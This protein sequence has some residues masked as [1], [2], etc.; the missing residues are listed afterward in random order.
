MK[1]ELF[2]VVADL[3]TENTIKTLLCSRQKSFNISLNFSPFNPPDGDLL[4]YAGR[5]AGCYKDAVDLLR[6][7]QQ[8]HQHALLF[9]DRHG[10]GVD[11]KSRTDIEQEVEE[12]LHQSG[13][14]PSN[15]AVIVL[16][17][18]LESWVWS[19]SPQVVE[20]LGWKNEYRALREYLLNCHFW[21][22]HAPKPHAPKEALRQALRKQRKPL[23]APLF[24]EL[25]SKVSIHHC[26]DPSFQKFQTCLQMWFGNDSSNI[27]VT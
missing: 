22:E 26:Q 21:D 6:T 27:Q 14:E 17:P 13:W 20:I 2:V 9:F 10:S 3:D 12:K 4:R 16:D 25:A 18:E 7:P 19:T 24:A 8:T 15:V 23:G 11:H 1:R 5:D